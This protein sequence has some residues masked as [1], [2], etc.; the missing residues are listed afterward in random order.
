MIEKSM[1][2]LGG[3]KSKIISAL[4]QASQIPNSAGLTRIKPQSHRMRMRAILNLHI[5]F[6]ASRD[7][8][9]A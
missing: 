3:L 4:P 6:C 2:V 8:L 5:P 7:I 1:L 9:C